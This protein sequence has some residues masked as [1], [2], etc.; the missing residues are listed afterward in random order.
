MKLQV[1]QWRVENFPVRSLFFLFPELLVFAFL[2]AYCPTTR[3]SSGYPR[4]NV[5]KRHVTS[6]KGGRRN[7]WNLMDNHPS[8]REMP[9]ILQILFYKEIQFDLNVCFSSLGGWEKNGGLFEK[10]SKQFVRL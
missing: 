8:I 4:E 10:K 5:L 2:F 7:G 1:S 6:L 9:A 3:H